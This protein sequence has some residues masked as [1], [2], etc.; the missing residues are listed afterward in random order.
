LGDSEKVEGKENQASAGR[1]PELPTL[2]ETLSK[3]GPFSLPLKTERARGFGPKLAERSGDDLVSALRRRGGKI[4]T[5]NLAKI[6][7]P[8]CYP[9]RKGQNATAKLE[10]AVNNC[11]RG[12]HHPLVVSRLVRGNGT[13][14]LRERPSV[15]RQARL[16]RT[17]EPA[18]VG[19]KKHLGEKSRNEKI[20][21]FYIRRRTRIPTVED[22]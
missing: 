18:G 17:G 9:T 21:H 6:I 7:G 12:L 10:R 8:S 13:L 11:G 14:I 1:Y 16:T 22:N 19:G 4:T 15:D 20:L 3:E 5:A 2:W